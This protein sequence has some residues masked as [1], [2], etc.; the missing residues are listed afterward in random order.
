MSEPAAGDGATK[1]A[2]LELRGITKRY[3]S[4][5]ANGDVDLRVQTQ[6]I[7][8]LIGAPSQRSWPSLG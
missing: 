2:A 8:A 7:H 5:V 1:T 6:S 3:G 4:L